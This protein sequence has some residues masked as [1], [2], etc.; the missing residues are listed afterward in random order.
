VRASTEPLGGERF[1]VRFTADREL[2][3]QI[4]ELRA[5]MR[6]Q[7]PDGDIAEILRRAVAVL[8]KQVRR[9]KFG[10]CSAPRAA[11]PA[12]ENASRNIPA[13]IRRAV[14]KRDGERCSYVAPSGRR[15][16]AQEFLE[17]HHCF[18]WARNRAHAVEGIALRCRAH[19]QH[20]AERDF[21]VQQMAPFRRGE[22]ELDLD[23]VARAGPC[24]ERR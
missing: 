2:H 24:P 13:A 10:E 11:K 5:L 15:C 22:A 20:A 16:G 4:Q 21:G 1:A 3:A 14:S 23:P 6:H 18:P 9:Q 8:L 17:F 7:V 12:G 19:N